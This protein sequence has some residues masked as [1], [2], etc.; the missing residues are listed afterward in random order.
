MEVDALKKVICFFVCIILLL[1]SIGCEGP[2]WKGNKTLIYDYK[3]SFHGEFYFENDYVVIRDSIS[4]KNATD[5]DLYFYMYAD[6][7]KDIGLV[8]ERN[9]PACKKDSLEKKKYFI[10]ANS[11]ELCD[12][13]FKGKKGTNNTKF[14]RLPP[15]D[16]RFEIIK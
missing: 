10:K 1:S 6:V 4:V 5:K 12:G 11:E 14:D 13:Y 7:S 9:V 3:K 15:N 16:I 2:G 8:V